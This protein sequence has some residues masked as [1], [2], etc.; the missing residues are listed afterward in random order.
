M[1][2]L[3]NFDDL[4]E[5]ARS[6]ARPSNYG[7]NVRF[8]KDLLTFKENAPEVECC[9]FVPSNIRYENDVNSGRIRSRLHL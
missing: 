3:I 1:S 7:G 9:A 4:M 5:N 6:E 8:L 2:Q